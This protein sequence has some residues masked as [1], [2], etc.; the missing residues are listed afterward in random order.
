MSLNLEEIHQLA[1]SAVSEGRDILL[2]YFGQLSKVREKELAGLVSEA[3]VE[4]EKAI[5]EVLKK[6][7]PGVEVLGEESSFESDL[8]PM[9]SMDPGS[10]WILDP[11][12]GTTNY[13]HGFY[14]Y[15]ISLALEWEGELVYGIVDAPAL[16]VTYSAKKGEGAFK[17]EQALKVSDRKSL[18]NSL[19]ATGFNYS[20][21]EILEQQIETFKHVIQDVRGVRRAGSAAYDLCLVAE[22]IYDA[23]WERGL[24]S[25]DMA[26]G[27]LIAAEAGGIVTDYNGDKFLPYQDSIVACN[28]NVHS[29][30]LQRIQTHS[31]VKN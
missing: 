28:P 22:G 1:Q 7:L 24:Q 17:N 18:S 5:A 14:V 27:A 12:D 9:K 6:G 29:T 19:V 30:L 13:V 4:S 26:A 3:D 11:L 31:P 10:R 20:R 2:R 8:D 16:N 23:Y 25:W 15:T 21:K